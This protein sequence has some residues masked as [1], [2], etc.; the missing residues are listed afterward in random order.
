VEDVPVRFHPTSEVKDLFPMILSAARLRWLYL[1][2]P[3]WWMGLGLTAV[4]LV[5]LPAA[6]WMWRQE[7][8]FQ[9]RSVRAVATITGKETRL[10]KKVG[11]KGEQTFETVHLLKYTF[12]DAAGRPVQG[13]ARVS[14]DEWGQ[15]NAGDTRAIEYD[16][17][18]PRDSRLVEAAAPIRWGLLLFGGT[19]LLFTS[20]GLTL[21]A[22]ALVDSGRRARLVRNGT[23]ALG[24]VDGVEENDAA[25]KVAGTYRLAYHFEDGA[26]ATWQGRGPAQ[27]WSLAARWDAGEDILVLYDPQNPRRNE[28]DVWEARNDDFDRLREETPPDSA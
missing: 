12:P 9:E 20:V 22:I 1:R 14:A 11:R 15:A 2:G 17:E 24:V 7:K 16:G 23:P 6:L 18:D 10:D 19:G 4:G 21:A 26:G 8:G 3:F 28:A 25:L 27:P 5:L 13:K